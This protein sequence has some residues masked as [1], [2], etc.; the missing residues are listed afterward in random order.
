MLKN[1]L[2]K[3]NDTKPIDSQFEVNDCI[4]NHVLRLEM[5]YNIDEKI[6]IVV[7]SS[8]KTN[9]SNSDPNN[10]QIVG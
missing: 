8:K 5:S 10:A 3:Q 9:V 2:E 6:F 4:P 1:V 7:R